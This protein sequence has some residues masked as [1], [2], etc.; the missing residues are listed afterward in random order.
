M[1]ALA[2]TLSLHKISGFDGP[3]IIDTPVARVSDENRQNFGVALASVSL[4]KQT[5][6]LFTPSEYS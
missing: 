1:L 6:L 2:F 4:Q 5:I 3:I